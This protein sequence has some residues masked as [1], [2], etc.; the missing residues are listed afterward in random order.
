MGAAVT[1]APSAGRRRHRRLP[2]IFIS[3]RTEL[4]RE[5]R[6]DVFDMTDENLQVTTAQ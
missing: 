4:H 2:D 6:D 5:E 3:N 1:P